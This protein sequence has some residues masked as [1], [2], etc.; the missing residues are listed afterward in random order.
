MRRDEFRNQFG[1]EHEV[2]EFRDR[3][4]EHESRKIARD[5]AHAI[6][7]GS[8]RLF[9]GANTTTTLIASLDGAETKLPR[10]IQ[11]VLMTKHDLL[12]YG[13]PDAL[14]KFNVPLDE[15]DSFFRLLTDGGVDPGL[16]ET[17]QTRIQSRPGGTEEAVSIRC[18]HC[19]KRSRV[20]DSRSTDEYVPPSARVFDL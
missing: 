16:C 6:Q 9:G 4:G 12:H 10:A 19:D 1:T 14:R 17:V 13:I 5:W 18:P 2:Y 11:G 15:A 20:I 3:F 8:H 7:F